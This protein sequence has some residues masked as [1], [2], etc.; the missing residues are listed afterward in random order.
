MRI[1]G[2]FKDLLPVEAVK[3]LS[4][5][6]AQPALISALKD[7]A[8]KLGWKDTLQASNIQQILQQT[9]KWMESVSEP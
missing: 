8:Q 7:A 5:L 2:P 9:G 4:Q 3:Q 1:P 6:V